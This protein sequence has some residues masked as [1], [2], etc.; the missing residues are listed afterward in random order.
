MKTFIRALLLRVASITIFISA[1]F[2]NGYA[3]I[4][5]AVISL[6]LIGYSWAYISVS[7]TSLISKMAK[8]NNRG[9]VMGGYNLI[10]SLGSMVG[11]LAGGILSANLSSCLISFSLSWQFL[12]AQLL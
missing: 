5:P 3:F 9:S 6:A 8:E 1:L 10:A 2:I 4:L 12:E 7:A 11:S